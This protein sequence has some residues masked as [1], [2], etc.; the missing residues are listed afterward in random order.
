MLFSLIKLNALE[1]CN[2]Y[3]NLILNFLVGEWESLD[4]EEN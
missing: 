4:D 1:Y 3:L 2:P